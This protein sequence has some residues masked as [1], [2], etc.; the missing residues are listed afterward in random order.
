MSLLVGGNFVK[1]FCSF[2]KSVLQQGQ[3]GVDV[4][5]Q[6]P[7]GRGRRAGCVSDGDLQE[8][9]WHG[10][11]GHADQL[12]QPIL[13]MESDGAADGSSQVNG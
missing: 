1:T 2:A 9:A 8:G 13:Y 6:R 10:V 7:V 3:P 12:E 11:S 5:E 4:Q